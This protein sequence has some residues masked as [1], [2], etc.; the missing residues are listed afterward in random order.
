MARTMNYKAYSLARKKI[1]VINSKLGQ[2]TERQINSLGRKVYF[3]L[4]RL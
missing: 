2:K 3:L 4:C 1:L